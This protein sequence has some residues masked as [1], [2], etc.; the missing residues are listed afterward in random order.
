MSARGPANAGRQMLLPS[1]PL[2]PV[3]AFHTDNPRE[4]RIVC[5]LVIAPRT[6]EELD[7]IA[8]ASNVPDA[9]ATLR[10]KGLAIPCCREPVTDKDRETVFR[11]RYSLTPSDLERTQHI[12]NGSAA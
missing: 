9:I 11:G 12:W 1:L 6:R 10:E 8:G 3:E 7:R 4:I 5:A 2:P